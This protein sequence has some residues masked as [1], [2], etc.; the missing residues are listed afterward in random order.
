MSPERKV[1]V[2]D[3]YD[4]FTYNIVHIVEKIL[5]Y[6]ISVFRNDEIRLEALSHFDDIIISPGPGL[7]KEAGITIPVIKKYSATKKIL[8]VCLG[9]QAIAEAFGA[10]LKNLNTVYHGVSTGIEITKPDSLFNGLPKI[11]SVGRYHSWVIDPSSIKGEIESIA[12]DDMGNC[13][14]LTHKKYNVKGLQFHPES[15]LTEYGEQILKN[16]LSNQG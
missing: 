10:Q 12:V 1:V 11:I 15:V 4:S 3:N 16:W 9:H 14:A 7:P 6:E 5:G 13:M 2:I 8:G